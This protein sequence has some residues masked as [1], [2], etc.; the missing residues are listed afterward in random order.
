MDKKRATFFHDKIDGPA[1]KLRYALKTYVDKGK[2]VIRPAGNSGYRRQARHLT[3]RK[4]LILLNALG[5]RAG[6]PAVKVPSASEVYEHRRK[7]AM[8]KRGK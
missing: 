4:L 5:K 6:M 1:R 3:G 2:V 8:K 7:K